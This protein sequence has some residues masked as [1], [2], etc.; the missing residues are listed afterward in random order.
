MS[1]HNNANRNLHTAK[2]AKKDEFYTQLADIE[3][4]LKHYH[5]HFKN[6]VV[7]CN[8]DDPRMSNFFH[9]FSYNFE[10][11]GLKKLIT[12]CYQN[13]SFDLA[14]GYKTRCFDF[15]DHLL[16]EIQDVNKNTVLMKSV[17]QN[18]DE[19]IGKL[20]KEELSLAHAEFKNFVAIYYPTSKKWELHFSPDE[21]GRSY[22][23]SR[24]FNDYNVSKNDNKNFN[25]QNWRDVEN[26]YYEL[27]IPHFNLQN[28]SLMSGNESLQI[29]KKLNEDFSVFKNLFE[30]YLTNII[31]NCE[32]TEANRIREIIFKKN[33]QDTV[34]DFNFISFNY[35]KRNLKN[36]VC[37][38]L[39]GKSIPRKPDE[40][41]IHIH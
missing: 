2:K 35:T 31:E 33:Q 16:K 28:K 12:T 19:G 8:C 22:F 24:L 17:N 25:I 39:N 3:N 30:N 27:L 20:D 40:K 37:E 11:L 34:D 14:E 18:G 4:E 5:H 10:D 38:I 7:Y 36:I 26:L 21:G 1:Q 41:I 9:Y 32:P 23:Y 13:Q 15:F 29:V 6:K